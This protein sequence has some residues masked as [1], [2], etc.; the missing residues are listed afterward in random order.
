MIIALA[1]IGLNVLSAAAMCG[2]IMTYSRD[3]ALGNACFI[4]FCGNV[5]LALLISAMI[6]MGEW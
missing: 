4:M 1:L 2:I 6:V 5:F 3:R